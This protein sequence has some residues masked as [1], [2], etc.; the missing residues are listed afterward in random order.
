MGDG[1][2]DSFLSGEV[3]SCLSIYG[4]G[5]TDV[6]GV[7]Q[8]EFKKPFKI[9]RTGKM[10]TESLIPLD[11]AAQAPENSNCIENVSVPSDSAPQNSGS[12]VVD[13]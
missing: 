4:G 6:F 2:I 9:L 7:C 1:L 11:E 10:E 3:I 13:F 8:K 5:D 12:Q